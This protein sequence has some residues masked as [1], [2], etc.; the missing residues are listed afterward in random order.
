MLEKTEYIIALEHASLKKFIRDKI[1]ESLHQLD[2]KDRLLV[3]DDIKER[4]CIWCGRADPRCP[5][6][7]DD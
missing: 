3:F 6:M 2:Y 1:I 7:N 4:F 5:C